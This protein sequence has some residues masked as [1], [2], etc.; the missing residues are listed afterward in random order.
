MSETRRFG[1]ASWSR[2]AGVSPELLRAW[3]RRYDLLHR[4]ARLEASASTRSTIWNA[5]ASC[6]ATSPRGS[7]RGKRQH[8]QRRARLSAEPTTPPPVRESTTTPFDPEFARAELARTTEAFD[9]PGAQ[10][11]LDE[12]LAVATI[13]VL[14]SGRRSLPPRTRRA[15]GARRALGGTGAL[16]VEPPA[17]TAARARSGLGERRRAEGVRPRARRA[18]DMTS[19]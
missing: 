19:A 11:V 3:E 5:F 4:R 14:P 16:R 13:H 2:R 15:L 1:L 8:S 18:S 7:P 12:L 9:E 6:P 10:T 17:R